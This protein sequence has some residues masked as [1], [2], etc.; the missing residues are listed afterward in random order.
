MKMIV[1]SLVT[2]F[3]TYPDRVRGL[4]EPLVL[5]LEEDFYSSQVKGDWRWSRRRQFWRVNS[6]SRGSRESFPGLLDPKL[7]FIISFSTTSVSTAMYWFVCCS[8]SSIIVGG[9]SINDY[10]NLVGRSPIRNAWIASEGS[11]DAVVGLKRELTKMLSSNSFASESKE[12]M[13]DGRSRLYHIRAGPLTI[14]RKAQHI[15][16][17]K[18]S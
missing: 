15:R 3:G 10:K 16:A 5:D 9:C 6:S 2:P 8:I 11:R 7:F 1:Y 17:S 12:E 18:V 13:N 14:V 4:E